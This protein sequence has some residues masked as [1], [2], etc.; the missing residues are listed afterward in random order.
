M[1]CLPEELFQSELSLETFCF[2][3]SEFAVCKQGQEVSGQGNVE[4]Q[5]RTRALTCR[6][7][8][9]S[10]VICKTAGESWEQLDV[11]LFQFVA[12]SVL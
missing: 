8:L 12:A 6:L 3:G 10:P 5:E 2:T 11:F 4:L 9:S 7:R 1:K